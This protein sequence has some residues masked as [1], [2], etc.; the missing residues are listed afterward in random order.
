[1]NIYGH[2]KMKNIVLVLFMLL[3]TTSG[4]SQI[5]SGVIAG[6]SDS[7]LDKGLVLLGYGSQYGLKDGEWKHKP[8]F[9]VGY[10][11]Q[12]D[13]KKSFVI[14]AALLYHSRG[15]HVA[16]NSTFTD[17]TDESKQLNVLSLNGV[18]NYKIWKGLSVGI[19][20]EPTWYLNTKIADNIVSNAL[21]F[22]LV[23][24]TGY[25]FK[26]MEV[27]LSYKYGFESIYKGVITKEA[28]PRDLRLSV[29]V[30]LFK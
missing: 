8:S 5:R 13:V 21:D 11:F 7:W 20:M 24:K 29:F 9:T 22:P 10:G 1:M 6:I 26:I 19:G 3:F 15:V 30:P 14:D 27:S 25:N 2:A 4:Y 12:F 18:V 28:V 23:V 17:F 16:Y